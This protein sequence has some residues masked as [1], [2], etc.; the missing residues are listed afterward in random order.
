MISHKILRNQFIFVVVAFFSYVDKSV[1]RAYGAPL[2]RV[3]YGIRCR[4]NHEYTRTLRRDRRGL[5]PEVVKI[6]GQ[7][8]KKF[9]AHT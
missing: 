6:Q 9:R 5:G 4:E 3:K 1:S 2:H 7:I 8:I